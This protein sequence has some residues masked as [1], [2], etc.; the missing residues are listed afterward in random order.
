MYITAYMYVIVHVYIC[1]Y[2]FSWATFNFGVL[3]VFIIRVGDYKV[4]LKFP[5]TS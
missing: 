1:I 5:L 4:A 2:A 3:C